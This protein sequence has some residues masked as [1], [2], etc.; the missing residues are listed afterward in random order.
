MLL[1]WRDVRK[2]YQTA[3][4]SSDYIKGLIKM[5]LYVPINLMMLLL[6]GDKKI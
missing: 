6:W 2:A 1:L 5:L 3:F 4:N